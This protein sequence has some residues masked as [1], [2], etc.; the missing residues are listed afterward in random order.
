MYFSLYKTVYNDNIY[1]SLY[2]MMYNNNIFHYIREYI[3]TTNKHS[4]YTRK[5]ITRM[6]IC[7]YYML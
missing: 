4:C 1:F 3:I 5:C 6:F 7:C 2:E